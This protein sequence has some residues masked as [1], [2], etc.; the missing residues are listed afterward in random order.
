MNNQK[1]RSC[2]LCEGKDIRFLFE[3]DDE[4][5]VQCKNCNLVYTNTVLDDEKFY[6]KSF[7]IG[8]DEVTASYTDYSQDKEILKPELRKRLIQI[9]KYKTQGRLLDV[10]CALG[11][12]LDEARGDFDTYGVEI[13]NFAATYAREKLGLQV[14]NGRFLDVEFENEFFDCITLWDV[15]EHLPDPTLNLKKAYKLL[16]S[17][18]LLVLSTGDINSFVSKLMGKYWHLIL[19][20]Q[21]IYYFS[22]DTIKKLLEKAGFKVIDIKYCGKAMTLT[23]FFRR[24]NFLLKNR[25]SSYLF[26]LIELSPVGR[27][28]IELNFYDIMTVL[29]KKDTL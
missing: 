10:G 27:M 4:A 14:T 15:I 16:K 19:P 9:K 5:I 7:F 2:N 24:V 20:P 6:S 28:R 17:D 8:K 23:H 1:Y 25:F 3:K 18:G 21:H 11:F 22:Q 29:A 13:S 12:F 26:R